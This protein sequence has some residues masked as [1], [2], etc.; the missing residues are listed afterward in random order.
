[1]PYISFSQENK[2]SEEAEEII[3]QLFYGDLLE[4]TNTNFIYS[5]LNYNSNT[6]FSGRET[7]VDQFNFS[8]QI[9][10]LNTKGFFATLTG[11]YLSE[12]IPSWDLTA[13]SMGY[14]FSI[15]NLSEKINF[16]TSYSRYFYSEDSENFLNS[17][18][19]GGSYFSNDENFF[20][21]I[22]SNYFFGG[23]SFF[24]VTANVLY[25]FKIIGESNKD[26]YIDGISELI[27]KRSY[28]GEQFSLNF[29][30]RVSF[31]LS[32]ENINPEY[33]FYK[34]FF[35]SEETRFGLINTQF[36]FPVY[37]EINR[38]S[39]EASYSINFPRDILKKET[40]SSTGFYSLTIG[41]LFSF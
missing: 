22:N 34:E 25:S 21:N 18:V 26:N 13:L 27:G 31:I 36:R 28:Q 11:I 15:E 41:Y 2:L 35:E 19:L 20:L 38:F 7:S 30:P 9:T 33:Y 16:N 23:E 14:Y 1:M 6:F 39:V 10:Y 12:V 3:D 24:Q 32:E 40:L 4:K 37:M 5:S 29:N 17:L 8:P